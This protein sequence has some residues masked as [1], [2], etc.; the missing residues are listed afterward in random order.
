MEVYSLR[1]VNARDGPTDRERLQLFRDV[2]AAVQYAHQN[3]IVHRDL[4]PGNILVT[5]EGEVKLL[6]FGIAKLLQED[7]CNA[8]TL[9]MV[10]MRKWHADL[11]IVR[12]ELVGM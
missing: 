10:Y 4:N 7:D 6:D 1:G 11:D 8:G 9:T 12:V 3:L 2:C 5:P